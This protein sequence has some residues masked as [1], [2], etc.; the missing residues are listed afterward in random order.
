MRVVRIPLTPPRIYK[1]RF[2][3]AL[4]IFTINLMRASQFDAIVLVQY[5]LGKRY[6]LYRMDEIDWIV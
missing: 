2:D 1:G 3:A 5:L 6:G 4:C